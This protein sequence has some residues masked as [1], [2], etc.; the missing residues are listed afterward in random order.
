MKSKNSPAWF[1]MVF[2]MLAG[3]SSHQ[4]LA[5]KKP[6]IKP[7]VV[8][9]VT[10]PG[11]AGHETNIKA[12]T[13]STL[14]DEEGYK[15]RPLQIEM[16]AG[17]PYMP[18]G[19]EFFTKEGKVPLQTVIK[20]LAALKGL[21]VSWAD[22]VK[23]ERL[24]DVDIRP[25]DNFWDALDN[26]LRQLDYF[27]ELSGQTIVVKYKETKEYHLAMPFL[28]EDFST[29]VGGDLLGGKSAEGR[30]SG[31][32]LIETKMTEPLD[33]WQIVEDNLF[34]IIQRTSQERETV[35]EETGKKGTKTAKKKTSSKRAVA[36]TGQGYFVID[37]PLGIITVTAPRKTQ[38]RVKTYLGNLKKQVYKQVVIEAKIIEV[39]L[40]ESTQLG[41]DWSDLLNTALQGVLEF[42]TAGVVYPLKYLKN[43]FVTKATLSDRSFEVL[44]HALDTYGNSRILSNPKMS[45]LNGH[46]ATLTVGKNVTYIDKVET[47]W[48][49]GTGGGY[50]YLTYT[51]STASV[52]SGV[53]M[54]VMAN[55]INDD[56]V[57]LYVVPITSELEE[58][59]FYEEFGGVEGAKIGLPVVRLKQL[60]TFAR[61]KQGQTMIIGGLIDEVERNEEHGVPLLGRLPLVGWLFKWIDDTKVK[62]ELV[63]LL[64]P[65][66]VDMTQDLDQVEQKL[67]LK[68]GL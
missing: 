15:I 41:I 60:A 68:K 59:I 28:N 64:K 50:G 65:T 30:M 24:V 14:E 61:L 63:I 47:T 5:E 1:F 53:G 27:Y 40:N 23:L 29:K 55:I 33:F 36:D 38:T 48:T 37:R 7:A 17:R 34:T 20:K 6:E 21:S 13:S 25:E 44:L 11:P 16:K 43:G 32:V 54:A 31:E 3:C 26:V 56:E 67:T 46:G 49:A 57:S 10:T 4:Q 35:A 51:V 66:I 62:R 12:K 22:D 8:P 45:I 19:A 18:V 42:G 2:L 58:P 52:L 9:P 39:I